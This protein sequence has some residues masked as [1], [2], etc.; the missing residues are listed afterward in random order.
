MPDGAPG[1]V[2]SDDG[3]ARHLVA[4]MRLPGLAL[5]STKGGE[6]N[7]AERTGTAILYVYPWTGR[8][9]YD[10]PPG[11]D[12]IAGAHG[13]TPQTAGFRDLYQAF[14]DLGVDVFG[15]STQSPEHQRE[16]DVRLA[17]PFAVLSDES[18]RF[19]AA[20]KLPTFMA[21]DMAYLRR[22]TLIVQEGT[23]QHVVYPVHAPEDH[24]AEI[25]AW[26]RKPPASD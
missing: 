13:S 19:Q 14:R 23:V 4:G 11:W 1:P 8:P 25:L 16:L 5:P 6:V 12:D 24:A 7:L 15:L 17:L 2:P 9:G 26:L 10:D 21:G 3:G 18:F 22:L 20:L